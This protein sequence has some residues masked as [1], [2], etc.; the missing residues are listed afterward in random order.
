MNERMLTLNRLNIGNQFMNDK[1]NASLNEIPR[2][3]N[4]LSPMTRGGFLTAFHFYK[5]LPGIRCF[6]IPIK[7]GSMHK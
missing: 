2:N 7:K 5:Y 4:F 3:Y 6:K 1:K